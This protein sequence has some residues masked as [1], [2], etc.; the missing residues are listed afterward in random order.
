MGNIGMPRRRLLGA[1]LGVVTL[2]LA[3][4]LQA[5][6]RYVTDMAGRRV[7]LPGRIER[8][9]SAGG[10]PAVNAFLFLFGQGERIVTGL[11]AAFQTPMW[12]LQQRFAPGLAERPV[13]SGPPPAWTPNL[14]SLLALRPDLC[15][16][17]SE[18]AAAQLERV[19]LAAIVLNWDK[20]DSVARTIGLLAEIFQMPRRAA[21]YVAWADALLA[22]VQR[23]IGQPARRPR[24][25]YLRYATLTQPIITPAN[26]LI[27]QAGGDSVTARDNP[28]QLDSVR[29]SI[30]QVLVWQPDVLLLA[31]G[32]ERA[33]LLADARLSGVPA[34]R[35]RQVYS[36]PHG[37]H[38]WTH[39][40]P[41]HPLGVLW[42]ARLLYPERFRDL[43]LAAE[44]A[45]FYRRFFGATLSDAEIAGILH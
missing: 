7:R 11:P 9:A 33:Q 13:V 14:E 2:C 44:T 38:I 35:Q 29:F 42:L 28:L 20:I 23:R 32:D 8:I 41:E 27:A 5:A 30:E 36:V 40:T 4:P 43:D 18:T 37:A 1:A 24:V 15:F 10:S 19:G 45:R 39:Y 26:H 25:L 34:I 12:R 6:E 3:S 17:V 31:L 16:V 21:D 22:D